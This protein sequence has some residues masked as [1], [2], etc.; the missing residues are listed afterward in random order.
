VVAVRE[1]TK[2]SIFAQAR[3]RLDNPRA[4]EIDTALREILKIGR[5]RLGGLVSD[6]E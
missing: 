4:E 2:A 6:G 5:L 1:H 3:E